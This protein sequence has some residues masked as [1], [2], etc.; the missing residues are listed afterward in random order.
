MQA[1]WLIPPAPTPKKTSLKRTSPPSSSSPSLERPARYAVTI[2]PP[3]RSAILLPGPL[4]IVLLTER[5]GG[6]ADPGIDDVAVLRIAPLE[7]AGEADL[8][9]FLARRFLRAARES[10]SVLL[11][12]ASLASL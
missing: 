8:A 5:Y 3:S 11:V 7:H 1:T 6:T 10:P 9:P 12:D 2:P 4:P